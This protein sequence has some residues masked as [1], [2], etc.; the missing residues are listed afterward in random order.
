MPDKEN[1][2]DMVLTAEGAVLTVLQTTGQNPAKLFIYIL[3]DCPMKC[4][5]RIF[6]KLNNG[7]SH[8]QT[9]TPRFHL[10]KLQ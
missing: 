10:K 5:N 8:M 3:K 9:G 6:R 2:G 1:K 7:G 4:T